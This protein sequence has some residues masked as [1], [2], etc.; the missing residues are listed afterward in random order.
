[1]TLV[2]SQEENVTVDLEGKGA[3]EIKN[4][5]TKAYRRTGE[6]LQFGR[7][8]V[9]GIE[10]CSFDGR[11]YKVMISDPDPFK[12]SAVFSQV[13]GP[14]KPFKVLSA[15]HWQWEADNGQTSAWMFYQP[16]D[17]TAPNGV[18][19]AEIT[20]IRLEKELKAIQQAEALAEL[21]KAKKDF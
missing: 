15:R 13:Y 8:S 4:V 7:E 11:F 6:K 12:L 16:P 3:V 17:T 1:M 5:H 19:A 20:N 21:G 2:E 18:S 14:A 9:G 10:Y